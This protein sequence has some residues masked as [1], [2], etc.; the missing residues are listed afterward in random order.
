MWVD[1]GS[2]ATPLRDNRHQRFSG[3]QM[4][5][6]APAERGVARCD[7]CVRLSTQTQI[8]SKMR[9][10]TKI[11][12]ACAKVVTPKIGSDKQSSP[13]GAIQCRTSSVVD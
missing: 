6:A 2:F 12:P 10:D 7:H 8:I 11:S 3:C 13:T 4:S 9:N 5:A 1:F